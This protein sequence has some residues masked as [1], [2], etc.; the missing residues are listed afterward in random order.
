[1]KK[2]LILFSLRLLLWR[3]VLLW[4]KSFKVTKINH[5]PVREICSSGGR[6]V[7]AFWHGSML[8]GWFLHRPIRSE[9]ISALVSRSNDGEYLSAVLE[10]WGYSM[11][12]GSSHIGGKEAM[13]LMVDEVENGS[14]LAI[15]PDGPRGPR[16]EMKMGAIRVAQKTGVP[17]ILA[18]IAAKRKKN[19]RSWDAFEVPIPFTEVRVVYSEPL[20]VPKDLEGESLDNFKMTM[21]H[22]LHELTLTAEGQL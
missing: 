17:L 21:Q 10:R 4:C 2:K 18:G 1:M 22:R 11:I 9:K 8:I 20:Y 13:Q 12:R 3:V 19:L 7:V 6:C 16:N 5:E 14:S 15:T